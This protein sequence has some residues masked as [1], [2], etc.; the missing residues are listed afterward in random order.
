MRARTACINR[1]RTVRN[2]RRVRGDYWQL[3][4]VHEIRKAGFHSRKCCTHIPRARSPCER[5]VRAPPRRRFG[6]TRV[7]VHYLRTRRVHDTQSMVKHGALA[8]TRA[9]L[10]MPSERGIR[11]RESEERQ[12]WRRVAANH[13]PS[14]N[15]RDRSGG[16][17]NSRGMGALRASLF[18][19]PQ[20]VIQRRH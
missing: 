8:A 16:T 5:G 19:A 15:A 9:S 1:V 11:E 20:R 10:A 3:C 4:M 18:A 17:V 14:P 13:P 2:L 12:Q 6:C 7:L